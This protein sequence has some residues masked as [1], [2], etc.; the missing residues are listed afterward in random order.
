MSPNAAQRSVGLNMTTEND[1]EDPKEEARKVASVA[2]GLHN[3]AEGVSP[4]HNP[5]GVS[6]PAI[7]IHDEKA[8][9]C[10]EGCAHY[11]VMPHEL[12]RLVV[13]CKIVEQAANISIVFRSKDTPRNVSRPSPTP[14]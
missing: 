10:I 6:V 5:A 11:V 8:P 7:A 13:L 12:N 14:R 9:L 3:H 2:S 4:H 1:W